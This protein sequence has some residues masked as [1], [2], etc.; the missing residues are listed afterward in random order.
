MDFKSVPNRYRPIPF[1]SWNEKLKTDETLRQIHMMHKVGIGGFIMHAR[2][3]LQTEYMQVEWFENVDCSV[4]EA[5]KLSM[6]AWAYDENGWPSGFGGGRVNGR[7]AKFQQK[8]LRMEPGEGDTPHTII[9]QDGYHFYYEI[10]PFYVDTLDGEVI[11]A[12][13]SEVYE[14]YYE[15]YKND[16]RGFFTDEPQISRNGIPWSLQLPDA[17]KA[18]YGE[19]LLPHLA[20]L[21]SA[22][23]DYKNTRI[24]FWKLICDL[25]SENCMKQIYDWC[26]RRSLLLTGHLVLEE[27]MRLQVTSNG[28]VMPHYE[29]FAMPGIDRLGRP[30]PK[31]ECLAMYQVASV[32]QQLGKKQV[33]SETFA[34]CG[35]NVSFSELKRI[36]EWQMVRGVNLLCQHLEGYSLRGIRK[37]DYPPAMYYQQPWWE[38]Y[39]IF[40]DSMSRIGMLLTE[41]DVNVNILLIHP[42]TTAWSMFDNSENKNIYEL[43]MNF[44]RLCLALEEKHVSFHLGDETIMERHARVEGKSLI[45]GNMRYTTIVMMPDNLLLDSTKTLL[46]KYKANGGIF[47]NLDEIP[48]DDIIDNKHV[49]YAKRL[50]KDFVMHY[51]V[52]TTEEVQKAYV[53]SGSQYMD[54]TTGELYPFNGYYEFAPYGSLVV[55]DD[56]TPR[57]EIQK[58]RQLSELPLGGEWTVTEH[59]PN[60]LTLDYCKYFFDGEMVEENGYVLNIQKRACD[61][62]RPVRIRQE[63]SVQTDCIPEELYLVIETPEIFEIVVNGKSVPKTDAGYFADSAFRKI[64]IGSFFDAGDNTIVLE[65]VFTQSKEVYENLEKALMFESELN[66]MTYDMEIE[67]IYLIGQFG[68]SH[69]GEVEKLDKDALRFCGNFRLTKP[70]KT[71]TL[72]NLEQQGFPFFAGTL[73]VEKNIFEEDNNQKLVFHTKGVNAVLVSVN[74]KDAAPVLWNPTELNLSAYLNKGEN[75]VRL[76]LINNLRNMMGPHHLQIGESHVVGP[77]SFFKESCIW[78]KNPQKWNDGYCFVEFGLY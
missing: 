11:A 76:T 28:A 42:Q 56:G 65:T 71:V 47:A 29:Y 17:Y 67:P 49:T 30:I 37:R 69:S 74:G 38:V 68:V 34:L 70:T 15:R 62:K 32:A 75:T 1:W 20:E 39:K 16:I 53:K 60:V 23:G 77:G 33:L 52:N 44:I 78:S 48:A 59:S 13:I 40:N 61:L 19:D 43:G 31:E 6:G 21:F 22:V 55:I 14:P 12:F 64:P 63:F 72:Q 25:F 58:E 10:N 54:I 18:A 9:N 45:I 4:A 51:F 35:H 50:Y 26:T 7:G 24:K 66:K 41:G 3:G 8:Y 73:T 46:E 5:Q 2:G 57:L 36:Y 27:S